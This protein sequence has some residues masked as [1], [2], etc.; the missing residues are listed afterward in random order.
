MQLPHRSTS[1]TRCETAA[2]HAQ[3]AL[4]RYGALF[5]A[6]PETSARLAALATTLSEATDVLVGA[7]AEY[8][9]AVIALI[10]ARVEVK[11][12]DLEADDVVRSVKRAADEAGKDV[13]AMV[14]EGGIT[15]I[16]RP[17]GQTEV[18][19]LR[20]LEGRIA[21]ATRWPD[22]AAQAARVEAVRTAYE[23]ALEARALGMRQAADK[24]AV[25]DAIPEDYLDTFVRVAAGVK[26]LFP[27][28]RARQ[29]VFF[30]SL[31]SSGARSAGADEA[32]EPDEPESDAAE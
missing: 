4:Q 23:A 27:R 31:R 8:R 1:I 19:T 6:G 20:A 12:V 11:L 17:V 2:R 25:R 7:Q 21:A 22:K 28:D 3:H 32:D 10:G 18:K 29:D 13:A 24:R 26:D 15:P 30:D 16:V 5:G 9:A 14:F